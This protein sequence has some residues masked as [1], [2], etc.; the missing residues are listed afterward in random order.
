MIDVR[1]WAPARISIPQDSSTLLNISS[2]GNLTETRP[3]R[4]IRRQGHKR[5][6]AKTMKTNLLTMGKQLAGKTGRKEDL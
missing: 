6:G 1:P 4:F 5:V 2:N 3:F